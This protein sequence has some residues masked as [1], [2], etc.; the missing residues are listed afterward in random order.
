MPDSRVDTGDAEAEEHQRIRQVY[1]GY[2]AEERFRSIWAD[3]PASR[4]MIEG[5]WRKILRALEPHRASLVDSWCLDLGSGSSGDAARLGI[6]EETTRGI[7]ALDLLHGP[8][9]HAR[10]VNSRL[11]A[12]AADAARMPLPDK[13]I[14][15]VYQSTMLS[16]VLD[17]ALRAGILAEIR[18]VLKDGGVFISYDTRFPNPWNRHTRPVT[19]SELERAFDGWPHTATSL[20]GI[21]QIVRLL[22]PLSMKACRLVEV[23]PAL[24]SHLLF[25]ASRPTGSR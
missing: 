6:F 23:I 5:K 2:D 25:L 16:S 11:V 22:A 15:A 4:Y 3:S 18:R 12:V 21:P 20:T 17:P 7:V 10:R 19:S 1:A 8:L 13:S 9:A 24:R 14:G